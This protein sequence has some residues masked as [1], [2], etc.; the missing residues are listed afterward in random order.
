VRERLPAKKAGHKKNRFLDLVF[1]PFW[2][3]IPS[4]LVKTYVE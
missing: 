4:E 1:G 3:I 2:F